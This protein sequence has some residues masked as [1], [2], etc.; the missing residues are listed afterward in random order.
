M[1]VKVKLDADTIKQS[2]VEHVEKVLFG[3][4]VLFFLFFVYRAIARER[5][6]GFTP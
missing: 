3:L 4:V 2:L 5:P 6:I 1:K